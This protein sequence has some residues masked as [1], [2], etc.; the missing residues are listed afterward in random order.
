M[1]AAVYLRVSTD[2]Q[3]D[4]NQ[5]PE[6][7]ALCKA[8]GWTPE[9]VR[10]VGSGSVA[11]PGWSRVL[12]LARTGRVVAVVFWSID[13]VG[14]SQVQVAHDLRELFRW[15][16]SVVSVRESWLDSSPEQGPMRGLLVDVMAWV[17][18]QERRR[19]IERTR[20][21]IERA[22]ERGVRFGRPSVFTDDV[23]ARV[24]ALRTQGHTAA[25]IARQMR[26][27]GHELAPATIRSALER[28][29]QW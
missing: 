16:V 25:S 26:A 13:R 11:R 9:L 27:E 8:R 6:T 23:R 3:D 19:L 14:R 29:G 18:E 15:R 20:A 24:L 10:E 21:G 4:A 1:R 12:E 5:E 28:A 22:R 7:V 17:A 2:R